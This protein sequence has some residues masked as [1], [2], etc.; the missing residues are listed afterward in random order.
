MANGKYGAVSGMI[1]RMQMLENISRQLSGVQTQSYKKGISTF[2]AELTEAQSGMASK[3]VNYVKVS[4]ETIDFTPGQ[5]EYSS[6]PLHVAINGDG[7][8][9][10][11]REDGTLA[12]TRKGAF[13]L[14]NEGILVDG[15]GLSVLST[16]G[17]P[18][19]LPSPDVS[20]TPDGTIWHGNQLYGQLGVFQFEDNSILDRGPGS[21]FVP[22]DGSEPEPLPDPE[23]AQNNLESSNV[24][25][26][27]TVVQMTT[28]MRA[29]ESLQKVL[30]A[31]NDM[32]TKSLEIGLVQ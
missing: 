11:E 5:M 13:R 12:Y 23:L 29:F 20:I 1:G 25:M 2:A 19:S 8:F 16:D 3:A 22:R 28:N 9:Q 17:D 10:L 24:N 14:N 26:M 6:N 31:Y 32:D 15:G 30:R 4:D 7:F 18:I 27:E 21:L